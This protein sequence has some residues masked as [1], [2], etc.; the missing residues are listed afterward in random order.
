M[1]QL[2]HT[3][4][5]QPAAPSGPRGPRVWS[6]PDVM[7]RLDGPPH[8]KFQLNKT[9]NR[10]VAKWAK[11]PGPSTHWTGNQ[12]QWSMSKVFDPKDRDDLLD[13]LQ[14]VHTWAWKKFHDAP[15]LAKAFPKHM[16]AQKPGEIPVD[17]VDHL[18]KEFQH[19]YKDQ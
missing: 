6:T 12:F 16:K 7:S 14:I 4:D 10:V 9:S 18:M 17:V 5:T 13:K 3:Q 2:L 19:M 8:I 1:A 11:E 15:D